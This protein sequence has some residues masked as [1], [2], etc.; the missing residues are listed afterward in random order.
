VDAS[1]DTQAAFNWDGDACRRASLYRNA[2]P[3]WG[4]DPLSPYLVVDEDRA[5]ECM[6]A[7]GWQ[8]GKN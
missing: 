7:R 5:A 3:R 6:K 8:P 1:R 4:E 2:N